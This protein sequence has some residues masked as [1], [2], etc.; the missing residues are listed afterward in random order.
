ML[1]DNMKMRQQGLRSAV[2]LCCVLFASVAV[3]ENWPRFRGP[4]GQGLSE[5]KGVPSKWS[6][7]DYNWKIELPGVGHS[8]PVAW[9][10]AVFVTCA[11]RRTGQGTLLCLNGSDGTERW[12]REQDLTKY[13]LNGLNSFASPTP[14]LD[15]EHV[16]VLWPGSDTTVLMALSHKGDEVWSVRLAGV[17][18]RHGQGSSPIVC[19]PYVIVAHEQERNNDGVR[20]QWLAVD[21]QTGEVVWRVSEAGVAN[22]SYSTPCVYQEEGGRPQLVFS[23]NAHGLTGVD[24]ESG[25]VLWEVRSALPYRV[26]SSPVIAGDVVIATCGEGGGGKRL[27]A[28]RVTREDPTYQAKEVYALDSRIVPYVPT[29]VAYQ[30]MLFTFHDGGV[31]SCLASDSGKVLWSEKPAGRYYGSPICVDGKLYCVTIDGDV[32]V[33][34]AEKEYKLLGVNPLGEKSHA[35]PAVADGRLLLRTVSHVISVGGGTK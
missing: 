8:S 25:K 7:Q 11:D 20:S 6:E 35:T 1:R 17:H 23:S 15:A 10:G 2:V 3:A 9:D 19:G 12:R 33:L 16:Y 32:V 4:N 30:G 22:A 31:V 13:P 29:S 18:A 24:P 5:A 34:A 21:R 14:A 28:V 26:V 27:S